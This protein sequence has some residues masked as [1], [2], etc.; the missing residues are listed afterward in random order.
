MLCVLVAILIGVIVAMAMARDLTKGLMAL[1]DVVTRF[2]DGDRDVRVKNRRRDELGVVGGGLNEML[3]DIAQSERRLMAAHDEAQAA[4]RAK[5]EFLANM[6]HE[7]RTPLNGVIGLA[8]ALES[9]PLTSRQKDMVRTMSESA[10]SLADLLSG[11]LDSARLEAGAVE[12]QAEAFPLA[13]RVRRVAAL[14]EVTARDKGLAFE[15]RVDPAAE[16]WVEGDALGGHVDDL[17]D[18]GRQRTDPERTGKAEQ[19][20]PDHGRTAAIAPA[21]S[22]SRPSGWPGMIRTL[23]GPLQAH[24]RS[25]DPDRGRA[26]RHLALVFEVDPVRLVQQATASRTFSERSPM[27]LPNAE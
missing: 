17:G 15:V 19:D 7:I 13:D 4:N 23:A 11:V 9:T 8:S 20:R 12:L 18:R 2:R 22:R 27:G 10:A 5:S 6:S 1:V 25:R 21:W 3:D 24:E 16:A 26:G 14:F